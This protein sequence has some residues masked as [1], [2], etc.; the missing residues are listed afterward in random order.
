MYQDRAATVRIVARATGLSEPVIGRAY[1]VLLGPQAVFAVNAGLDPTRIARTIQTMQQ[2]QI[3]T[4]AAPDDAS[5]VDR[6]P[7]T[8]VI[9]ELGAWTDD[10]RWH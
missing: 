4:G 10:P 8:A 7:I 1:D 9:G 2:F 6:G 5:L 3:L